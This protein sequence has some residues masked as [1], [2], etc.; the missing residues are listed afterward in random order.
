MSQ[1]VGIPYDD[2]GMGFGAFRVLE[3]FGAAVDEQHEQIIEDLKS[4]HA[5]ALKQFPALS[6]ETINIGL[7]DPDADAHGRARVR[8]NIVLYPPDRFTSLMTVYHELGHLAIHHRDQRGEDVA[9]TSEN[10]CSIFSVA[11][12]PPDH[13]DEDRIPYL[14]QPSVPKSEWPEICRQA[15]EY[16]EDHHNYIQ[17]CNEWLGVNDQEADR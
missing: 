17:Q 3:T 13:I 1:R 4:K 14:G 12:M 7:I 10:F 11:R 2:V 16:R 9:T 5:T 15:L 6:G 8:N